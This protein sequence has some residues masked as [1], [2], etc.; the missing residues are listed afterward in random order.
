MLRSNRDWTALTEA[1]EIEDAD[2]IKT[3]VEAEFGPS[4]R[5]RFSRRIGDRIGARL[6]LLVT[7]MFS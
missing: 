4:P 1:M 2:S 5:R 3:H 7:L 6:G